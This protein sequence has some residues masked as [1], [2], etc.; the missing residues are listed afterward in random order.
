MREAGQNRNSNLERGLSELIGGSG[1]GNGYKGRGR[2]ES[3]NANI[4]AEQPTNICA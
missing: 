2:R 4:L 3:A 1:G